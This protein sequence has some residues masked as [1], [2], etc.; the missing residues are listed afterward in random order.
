MQIKEGGRPILLGRVDYRVRAVH[1]DTG[2]E[3]FNVSYSHLSVLDSS[4]KLPTFGH[5]HALDQAS[6]ASQL[7]ITLDP[8]N[9]N[10]IMR[11]SPDTNRK[12]W[13]IGFEQPPIT[14]FAGG[15]IGSCLFGEPTWPTP[16]GLVTR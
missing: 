16:E 11:V 2:I 6:E 4:L 14:L 1:Q 10:A 5:T 13:A 15:E 8:N 12:M 7:G 3:L 9:K